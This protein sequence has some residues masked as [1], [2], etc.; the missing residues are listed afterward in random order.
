MED[1]T[2]LRNRS[3]KLLRR[4]NKAGAMYAELSGSRS[5]VAAAVTGLLHHRL[6]RLKVVAVAVIRMLDRPLLLLV[7]TVAVIR[8]LDHQLRLKVVEAE[9]VKARAKGKN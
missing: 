8:P 4:C 2:C 1:L 7:A 9:K 5:K 3:D 6:L